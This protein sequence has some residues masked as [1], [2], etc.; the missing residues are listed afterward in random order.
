MRQRK[1][2][3]RQVCW[4]HVIVT[5]VNNIGGRDCVLKY[6]LRFNFGQVFV[7]KVYVDNVLVWFNPLFPNVFF[8]QYVIITNYKTQGNLHIINVHVTF[9]PLLVIT[10]N[11]LQH[12][13]VYLSMLSTFPCYLPQDILRRAS[14]LFS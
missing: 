11:I 10:I 12:S 2:H 9:K 5:G 14:V 6:P 3:N 7:I 13:F 1:L 8:I 4:D